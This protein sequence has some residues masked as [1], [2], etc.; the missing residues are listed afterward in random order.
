MPGTELGGGHQ[1][2][3]RQ[4]LLGAYRLAG[5]TDNRQGNRPMNRTASGEARAMKARNTIR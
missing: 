4:C 2:S 3:A 5:E 1:T